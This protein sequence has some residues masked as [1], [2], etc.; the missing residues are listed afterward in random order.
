MEAHQPRLD[1]RYT[2]GLW[3]DTMDGDFCQ[4]KEINA[5]ETV[6]LVN[7][8]TG[9]T[10]HHI[11]VDQWQDQQHDFVSVPDDA[12]ENPVSF[13]TEAVN[14]LARCAQYNEGQLPYSEEIGYRYAKRQV[15]VVEK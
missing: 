8:E 7:P 3:Y 12:V 14:A 5:G 15:K 1:D 6:G 4:I 10:Y 13:Y 11:P 9:E 2:D